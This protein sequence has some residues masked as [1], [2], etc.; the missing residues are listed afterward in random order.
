VLALLVLLSL[1]LS[2]HA[3]DFDAGLYDPLAV[4]HWW[5]Y[6]DDGGGYPIADWYMT[7]TVEG[8]DFVGGV[9]T[10][11]IVE[12]GGSRSGYTE[13]VTNDEDGLRI[14]RSV[15]PSMGGTSME[16]SPPLLVAPAYADF[17]PSNA[18]I[19]GSGTVVITSDGQ[20]PLVRDYSSRSTVVQTATDYYS[21]IG[22]VKVVEVVYD[23]TISGTLPASGAVSG[24]TWY[25]VHFAKGLGATSYFRKIYGDS[26][27]QYSGILV[28]V[29]APEPDA[30]T[31]DSVSALV[32]AARA[33]RSRR[34]SRA[35]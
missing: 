21:P 14:H 18:T 9:A 10:N 4:G 11:R 1:G 29:H 22:D 15:D 8:I 12:T 25:Q 26:Y 27:S 19:N 33:R 28:D 13:Y 24:Y 5:K 16:F 3:H 31:L 35:V 6:L 2:A 32:I 7:R 17:D 34:I 20:E 30:I 23:L